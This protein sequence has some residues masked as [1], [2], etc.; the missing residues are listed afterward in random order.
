VSARWRLVLVLSQGALGVHHR[1]LQQDLQGGGTAHVH[2]CDLSEV[3]D[4][5]RMADEVLAQHGHV[6]VLV[7]NNNGPAR[8]LINHVGQR[9]RWVGLRLVG[10][11][12]PRP[13]TRAASSGSPV[14]AVEPSTSSARPQPVEGR[15]MLG[16]RVGVFRTEGA[17]LWRRARADGSYASASDPRVLVGLGNAAT[18]RQVRVMWPSGRVETWTD[19]PVDRW[20]TLKEG[21]GRAQE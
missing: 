21:T 12:G 3:D 7:T 1:A 4:I 14:S 9:S 18:V 15:D 11:P 10:G 6:D 2:P 8:L 19:I 17:P 13:S 5:D 20:L 16:A